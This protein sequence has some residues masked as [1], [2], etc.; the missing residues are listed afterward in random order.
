MRT[1]KKALRSAYGL[2]LPYR[3]RRGRHRPRRVGTRPRWCRHGRCRPLDMCRAG[4]I[5]G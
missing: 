3:Q 1:V 4:G 5:V 2:I